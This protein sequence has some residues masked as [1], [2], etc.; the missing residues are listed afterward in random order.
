MIIRLEDAASREQ[1]V[2]TSA[3]T[4]PPADEWRDCGR[5]VLT[6]LESL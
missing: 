1:L 6:A 2:G 3:L 5:V 4:R